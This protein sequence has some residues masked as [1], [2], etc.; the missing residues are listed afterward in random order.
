[1]PHR[2]GHAVGAPSWVDLTTPDPGGA[3]A[4]YAELF[5][6]SYAEGAALLDGRLAAG[7]G[8]A[9]A[10]QS[11]V[12]RTH[13]VA[14]DLAGTLARVRAAGGEVRGESG[15]GAAVADPTGAEVL[16]RQS[17][18]H[19][20][21]QVVH[22]HGALTWNELRTQDVTG[23]K[24]FYGK[25]FDYTYSPVRGLP[26]CPVFEVDGIPVASAEPGPTPETP[27]HW[28]VYFGSRDVEATAATALRAGGAVVRPPLETAYGP[29][30]VL[31]DPWG[32]MFAVIGLRD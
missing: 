11:S 20:G 7:V 1:M 16:F 12:W 4:F 32:A 26:D 28:L 19:S 17:G 3:K 2:D 18:A 8:P 24:A 6:W 21:V 13:L 22:E 29:T 15:T 5:G 27:S 31:A 14:G 10:G 9:A 23:A 30:A 25:L